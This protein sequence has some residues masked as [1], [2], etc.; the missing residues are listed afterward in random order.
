MAGLIFITFR[1]P[2]NYYLTIYL[3]VKPI[4][5]LILQTADKFIATSFSDNLKVDFGIRANNLIKLSSFFGNLFAALFILVFVGGLNV[6]VI[7]M[8]GKS[9]NLF[10]FVLF[11]LCLVG[12]SV[13]SI[14]Y[15]FNINFKLINLKARILKSRQ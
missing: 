6:D 1:L 3:L 11:F 5:L 2:I 9:F 10:Y 12:A 15:Y 13:C 8:T 4:N 7:E 14:I